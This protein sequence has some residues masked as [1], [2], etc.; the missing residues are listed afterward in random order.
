[1]SAK[2]ERLKAL[3]QRALTQKKEAAKAIKATQKK[4][5][6]V[7]KALAQLSDEDLSTA[8]QQRAAAKAAAKAA[9]AP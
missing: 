9:A 8:V 1:M 3:K 5:R 6:K 2:I 7:H 4:M